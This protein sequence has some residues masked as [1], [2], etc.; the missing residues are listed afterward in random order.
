MSKRWMK[1]ITA[2]LVFLISIF[3]IDLILNR[4]TSDMTTE[5]SK[6]TLPVVSVKIGQHEV[7]TMYGYTE[8]REELFTKES[9]T[10]IS[11]S[12]EI[13]MVI[14]LYEAKV[15]SVEY[16]V[17]SIDGERL[18]EEAEVETQ[19][20]MPDRIQFTVQLKDLIQ[21]DQEYSFVTILT[22]ESSEKI[23]YYTRLVQSDNM[24]EKEKLDFIMDFHHTTFSE[25]GSG[26]KQYLESNSKGDNTNFHKTDI[27]SSLAQVMWDQLPVEK[28]EEPTLII[29]NISS[30]TASVILKYIVKERGAIDRDYYF[31]EEYYRVRYT[32]N[33]MYLLNYERTVDE[34]F[35]ADKNSFAGDKIYLGIT[36]EKVSMVE[37]EGGKNLA[38]INADRLFLYNNV[39]NK[40][41]QVFAFYDKDNFDTRT[42]N[43][44]FE[45]KILKI[46]D[47]GNLAFM[48]A[49]Y[50][51]RGLHEGEV[52]IVVYSYDIIQN[53]IEEQIFIPYEKSP[54]ILRNELNNLCYLNMEN[55]LFVILQGSLYDISLEEK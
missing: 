39:D 19:E 13:M 37:S 21:M 22:T 38:F 41:S 12:R 20:W 28:I 5:M 8:K 48:V 24:F 17:R 33:R 4:T 51:N 43:R 25:D 14:D 45:I 11:S 49:G 54:D 9:V 44:N 42:F 36:D 27:H 30:Q 1:P 6:A 15:K 40:L 3:V 35:D 53:T 2:I 32:P 50:M 34:I 47:S 10:P 23:Y 52:G 55:H 26:I 18:I 31:V 29:K 46:E 7:N 16:E